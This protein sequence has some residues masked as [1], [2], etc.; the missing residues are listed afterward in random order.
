MAKGHESKLFITETTYASGT[1]RRH[2]HRT[3]AVARTFAG[4]QRAKR[5]VRRSTV[6]PATW[7][8]DA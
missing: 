7:G 2:V 8:P 1:V 4:K 3:R 5:N 6:V